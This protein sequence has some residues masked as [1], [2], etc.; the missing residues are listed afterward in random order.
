MGG[1]Y[2]IHVYK[3][4]EAIVKLDRPNNNWDKSGMYTLMSW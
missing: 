2:N 4:E 1:W 3:D